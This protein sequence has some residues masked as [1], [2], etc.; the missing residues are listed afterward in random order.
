MNEDEAS[1]ITAGPGGQ[2]HVIH[3]ITVLPL[4]KVVALLVGEELWEE[5]ELRNH[6]LDVTRTFTRC[7]TPS[8]FNRVESSVWQ[9][10]FVILNKT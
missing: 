8:C 1:S 2:L 6:L 7:Q 3:I 9:V 4:A 5:E 10:K